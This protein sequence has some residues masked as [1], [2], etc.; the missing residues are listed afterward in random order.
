MAGINA[1]VYPEVERLYRNLET[2]EDTQNDSG[3][4]VTIQ[5]DVVIIIDRDSLVCYWPDS[6]LPSVEI[7]EAVSGCITLGYLRAALLKAMADSKRHVDVKPLQIFKFYVLDLLT[8]KDNNYAPWDNVIDYMEVLENQGDIYE[9]RNRK[10]MLTQSTYSSA[11]IASINH[12]N[13]NERINEI[14]K[15]T[16]NKATLYDYSIDIEGMKFGVAHWDRLPRAKKYDIIYLLHAEI[17]RPTTEIRKLVI[18]FDPLTHEYFNGEDQRK[19]HAISNGLIRAD[20][21]VTPTLQTDDLLHLRSHMWFS[22]ASEGIMSKIEESFIVWY[23][24]YISGEMIPFTLQHKYGL[25]VNLWRLTH[26]YLHATQLEEH[27]VRMEMIILD[28]P[29]CFREQKDQSCF[30]SI[31]VIPTDPLIVADVTIGVEWGITTTGMIWLHL[32]RLI[33]LLNIPNLLF[34]DI[35]ED[36]RLSST[37]KDFP[38]VDIAES[39]ETVGAESVDASLRR[40]ISTAMFPFILMKKS[41]QHKLSKSHIVEYLPRE[42]NS[43]LSG[44]AFDNQ[45][46]TFRFPQTAV[47]LFNERRDSTSWMYELT[48]IV[49]HGQFYFVWHV[50]TLGELFRHFPVRLDLML[51]IQ[52]ENVALAKLNHGLHVLATTYGK[53]DVLAQIHDSFGVPLTED[54]STRGSMEGL[55]TSTLYARFIKQ[56]AKWEEITFE[57]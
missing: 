54:K 47:K 33:I 7:R 15:R 31:F 2:P 17:F 6:A 18:Y 34:P 50:H 3:M 43:M 8:A 21:T 28:W 46:Q 36:F 20:I 44:F 38:R 42:F 30:D 16:T 57:E 29:L 56:K 40:M 39:G 26:V 23:K 19:S 14:M 52:A 13:A 5:D 35:P 12:T 11:Q 10:P 32:P 9:C 49:Y 1:M 55:L 25:V 53:P 4:P 48:I 24:A 22:N 51:S 41:H 37:P 27:R 45:S